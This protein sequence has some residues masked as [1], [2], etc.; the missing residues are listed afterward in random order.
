MTQCI[1]VV[2]DEK[3]V[4]EL[5]CSMLEGSG[6]RAVPAA[7]GRQALEQLASLTPDLVITDVVMPE[8]DGLEVLLGLRRLAPLAGALVMSGGGRAAPDASL[9]SARKLGA[10]AVLCKPFTKREMLS[11]VHQAL[12]R[13][14]ALRTSPQPSRQEPL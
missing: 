12:A 14:A 13:R 2:D 5:V 9:E 10:G 7:G 11:A 6:Y 4:R 3:D 8:V 1:L